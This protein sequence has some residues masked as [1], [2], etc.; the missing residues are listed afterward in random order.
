[1]PNEN[2][3]PAARRPAGPRAAR[4]AALILLAIAAAGCGG[5][6][7]PRGLDSV[8][9]VTLDTTRADHVSAYAPDSPASTPAL[10]RLAREGAL[11]RRAWSTVPLT[12]PAHA[13]ILTG[14]YPPGHGV[15][16]NARFRLPDDV[17]TLAEI[18]RRHGRRTAAVSASFTT[19]GMFGLAQGFELYDDDYGHA[20]DGRRRNT[21]RGD[22]VVARAL[23]WLRGHADEPFLLWVHLYD[24]HTPWAPPAEYARRHRGDPYSGEIEFTDA[25]VGRLLDA[26]DELGIAD[27]TVV[28]AI[29]D[30]GEGLGTHGEQEHGLLLYEEALHVPFLLRAPGRIAP[31]TVIEG[32]ASLVDVL[33][34]ALGL[35]GLEPPAGL[36]GRDLLAEG[37]AGPV[38]AETLYPHEEFGWSALYALREA[39][40]KLI[41]GTRPELYDLADDPG[42]GRD[43]SGARPDDVARLGATLREIARRIV[44]TTR[45]AAAAGFGGGTDPE[46]IARLESLG[47]V[48]GGGGADRGEAGSDD[49]PLPAREGRSP[50]EAIDDYD[51]FQRTRELLLA[52]QAEAAA[53]LV[54]R[55]LERDPDNPQFLLRLARARQALGDDPGTEQVFRRL[56]EVQPTFY[57]GYRLYATFLEERGRHLEARNLWLRL[58][59]LL[60][61]Y[62]GLETR[63]AAAEL[64]AGLEDEAAARLGRYLERRPDDAEGW[65]LLG[66]VERARGNADAALAAF[67]QALAL[68]P[69][70]RD[71]VEG[72]LALLR[73]QGRDDEARRLLATLR[74]RAPG[75]PFLERTAR[76]L[77]NAR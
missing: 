16:N 65:E 70:R 57:L 21:R 10:E 25:M 42:E 53:R 56:I 69:T 68:A 63:L 51:R 27:R 22:E 46:T 62:V 15:R 30:H 33:P 38:Y 2:G 39:D 7:R 61:G 34:T 5:A 20:P 72:A 66:R 44:D 55:L 31:G 18:V 77:E 40:L 28:I 45:L 12:T 19:A 4:G 29:A 59:G 37:A 32:P 49:D 74:G 75:D 23:S 6:S 52:G 8:L 9:L 47:Y 60:P 43:L 54:E 76:T 1:M 36:H 3:I 14:L 50:R 35:L 48:A 17:T 24:P 41:E 64:G 67:R 58:S 71:A 73:E 26:L 13:S 11:V